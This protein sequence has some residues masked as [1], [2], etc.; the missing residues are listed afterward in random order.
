[1][2]L[3]AQNQPLLASL[4]NQLV[5]VAAD[6][7][8]DLFESSA[9]DGSD[10]DAIAN[11]TYRITG[12]FS[13]RDAVLGVLRLELREDASHRPRSLSKRAFA[14]AGAEA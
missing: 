6:V 2:G 4:I 12:L 5:M 9:S 7:D 10:G 3:D 13:G 11:L 14:A 1:M 8:N